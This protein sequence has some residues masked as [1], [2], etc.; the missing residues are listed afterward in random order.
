MVTLDRRALNAYRGSWA[1]LVCV[2]VLLAALLGVQ[3]VGDRDAAPTALL[4]A[5]TLLESALVIALIAGCFFLYV[6]EHGRIADLDDTA[7]THSR[8]S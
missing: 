8:R 7:E 3:L 6:R 2:T 4:W 5:Q 1:L